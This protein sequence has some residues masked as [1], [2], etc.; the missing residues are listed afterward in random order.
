[1]VDFLRFNKFNKDKRN[2]RRDDTRNE[3][4]RQPVS[5]GGEYD[6][7]IEEV[8]TKGDGIARVKGFVIF[9]PNTSK[10]E[11]CKIKIKEVRR[12]FAVGEKVTGAPKKAESE[13]V[14]KVP[15]E[16]IEE[17]KEEAPAEKEKKP[18]EEPKKKVEEPPAEK[19]EEK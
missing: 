19:V 7:E 3:S 4:F 10:G 2:F 9:V 11:K 12:R 8:G 18:A 17:T 6:V 14:E 16:K 15:A 13:K 5:V 1:M